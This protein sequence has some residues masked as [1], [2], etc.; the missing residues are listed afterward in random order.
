MNRRSFSL[1]LSASGVG[2]A[3]ASISRAAVGQG[4]M[5]VEGRDYK[6]IE[7]AQPS[8]AERG[9]IEVLEFFS[10]GCPHCN[11][12]EP[13]LAAW[14][15]GLSPDVTFRRVPVP[16]LFNAENFQRTYYALDAIGMVD[17][18]QP[19]IYAAV[20]IDKQ[21]L[22]KADQVAALV[23]NNGG[24]PARFLAAFKSFAVANAVSRAKKLTADYKID[25]VPTLV[26]QKRY[27][28][29]P[30]MAGGAQQALSVAEALI[31]RARKA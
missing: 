8:P 1:T 12:F 16:F 13:T 14:A 18:M 26:I 6:L 31:E 3:F 21:R 15:R 19:R 20:H 2:A 4:T 7:S 10:Y 5:P 29:S 30:S 27:V 28:T 22:D 17:K 24:D 23:S 11:A 9:K 25:G